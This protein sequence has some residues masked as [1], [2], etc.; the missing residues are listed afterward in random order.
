MID[1]QIRETDNNLELVDRD[2][3]LTV[4]TSRYVAQK[5]RVRLSFF[6]GE[7]YLN[8]EKG[9]PYYDEI[10]VKNPNLNFIE[11]LLKAEISTVPEVEELLDFVLEYEGTT[12]E[13]S[14]TFTVRI[15]SGE[16][17]TLTI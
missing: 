7:W 17:L 5:L 13:L 11:D 8:A 12:R 10:L 4:D 1:F 14:V 3:F 9:I 2:F 6:R 16:T 15:T